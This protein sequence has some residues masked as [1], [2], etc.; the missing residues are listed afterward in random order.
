VAHQEAGPLPVGLTK[1]VHRWRTGADK[2]AIASWGVIGH[3][4]QGQF[5]SGLPR[6][7]A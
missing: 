3:L 4:D 7:T 1:G 6:L 5:R 2:I